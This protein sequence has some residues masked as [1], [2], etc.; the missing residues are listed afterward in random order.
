MIEDTQLLV[1][2][3]DGNYLIELWLIEGPSLE[4]IPIAWNRVM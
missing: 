3:G 2:S 4:H 1:I